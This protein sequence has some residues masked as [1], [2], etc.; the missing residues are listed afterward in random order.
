MASMAAILNHFTSNSIRPL[1]HVN[2]LKPPSPSPKPM[3][4]TMFSNPTYLATLNAD[5][6]AHLERVLLFRDP[7]VVHQPM[8]DLVF[9]APKTIA[10]ALCIM[11]CE[12]VGGQRID[13]IDA[14]SALN[15]MLAASHTHQYLPNLLQRPNPPSFPNNIEL[16]TGDGIYPLGLE[17]LVRAD[18][19]GVN[20]ERALR[21]IVEIA[22]A[23]GGQGMVEAQYMK[24]KWAKGELDGDNGTLMHVW[25]RGE[26]MVHSCAAACGAIVG[27]ACEEDVEKLRKY[28]FYVGMIRGMLGGLGRVGHVEEEV[29]ERFR[30]LAMK[31]LV[32][33]DAGK[34]GAISSLI[35]SNCCLNYA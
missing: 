29:V 15:L 3:R 23:M 9:S 1:L 14:A 27:G 28:G 11:A 5:I 19:K 2:K 31:E 24:V 13:A 6:D 17:L 20:S 22:R 10:P 34:V 26:G 33:L 4:V 18:G 8:H 35:D 16:L 25:E 7:H 32:G 21:V 12:L 30:S